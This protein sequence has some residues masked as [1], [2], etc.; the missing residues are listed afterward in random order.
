MRSV[1]SHGGKCPYHPSVFQYAAENTPA[2]LQLRTEGDIRDISKEKEAWIDRQ[3]GGGDNLT[4]IM[5]EQI[6][7]GRSLFLSGE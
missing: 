2:P 1:S 3:R 4:F 5:V 6:K 7:K